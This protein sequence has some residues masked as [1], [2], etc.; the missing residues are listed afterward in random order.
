MKKWHEVGRDRWAHRAGLSPNMGRLLP[1]TGI[2][3]RAGEAAE[4]LF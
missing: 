3:I 4:G 1:G 2:T